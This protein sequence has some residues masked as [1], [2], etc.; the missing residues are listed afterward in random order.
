[1]TA[2]HKPPSR[3]RYEQRNPVFSVRM[4]KEWHDALTLYVQKTNRSK[5]EFMA[6]ALKQITE[7]YEKVSKKGYDKG[8]KDGYIDGVKDGKS[9]GFINGHEEGKKEGYKQ[10]KKDWALWVN[11][12]SCND[13][14]YI[15]PGTEQHEYFKAM[16]SREVRYLS[17][18][19]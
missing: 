14:V 6:L 2:I 1:M 4:P 5:K 17:C 13:P 8:V 16:M 7:D 19:P 3:K 9:E 10:G 11:C 18:P 15:P 12:Y